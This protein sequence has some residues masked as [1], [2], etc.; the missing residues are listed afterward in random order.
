MPGEIDL[1]RNIEVEKALLGSAL[2]D[3]PTVV[4]AIIETDLSQNDFYSSYH[5]TILQHV[6]GLHSTRRP[7]ELVSVCDSM[8]RAGDLEKAG[9]AEY[10]A[11]L[12]DGVPRPTPRSVEHYCRTILT[13]SRKRQIIYL[14]DNIKAKA[15]NG[16]EDLAELQDPA[17]ELSEL[18]KPPSPAAI[19]EAPEAL[20]HGCPQIPE[21][22]WHPLALLYRE[23][24]GGTTEA[25]DNYHLACFY[26]IVGAMLGRLVH[27]S[28]P[29]PVYANLFTVLV[30]TS[31][32]PRKGTAMSRAFRLRQAVRPDCQVI[33]SI[34][35][36]E[37]LID[38]IAEFQSENVKHYCPV[39][40]KFTE[41]RSLIDKASR[42]GARNI[43]PKL[44]DLYDCEALE[45]TLS[46]SNKTK[47]EGVEHSY[48][49]LLA[50]TSL[51]YMKG[52]KKEDIEGGLGSRLAFVPGVPKPRQAE[53][54]PPREPQW[55]N[56]IDRLR[57]VMEFWTTHESTAFEF[58]RDAW[59]LWK[60]YYEEEIPRRIGDHPLM[61]VL[62]VR[63]HHHCVKHA[64]VN[65]ALDCSRAFEPGHIISAAHFG[66][67]LISSLYYVF[68]DFGIS[69]WVEQEH[70][71]IAAVK[72]AGAEGVRRR[73]L[74]RRFCGTGGMSTKHFQ[75]MMK[76]LTAPES[77][78]R[79]VK[80]GSGLR[81][82]WLVAN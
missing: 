37:G 65:A 80:R 25:P 76:T 22:A 36:A 56:L 55:T 67:F 49:A 58:S 9:G 2:I 32:E 72:A 26:T 78:L 50:G 54:P 82:V 57:D 6:L 45:R 79:E 8:R 61:Q 39:V 74:Q 21:S 12:L 44:C 64:M 59:E 51:A 17:T 47:R 40:V 29:E 41:L 66:N 19:E 31:G 43:M 60:P 15:A 46:A 34:D 38:R 11:S 81:Q 13:D 35:S 27:Y 4:P 77:Y 53:T 42:E 24:V 73:D 71:I 28:M 7:V 14:C 48:G 1:P 20:I 33:R 23:A 63:L 52:L 10:L 18:V 5:R 3:S 62:G 30:G 70:K 75:D 16:A 69:P 68:S